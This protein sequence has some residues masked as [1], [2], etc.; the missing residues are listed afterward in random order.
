ML[1]LV[2]LS[3]QESETDDALL[4]FAQKYC[5]CLIFQS[6][7][8][9]N[10]EKH[11]KAFE[12]WRACLGNCSFISA[13]NLA[14][15]NFPLHLYGHSW[16]Q[17]AFVQIASV[18]ILAYLGFS[19]NGFANLYHSALHTL[20]SVI[21]PQIWFLSWFKPQPPPAPGS[22]SLTAPPEE[23]GRELGR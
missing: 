17:N 2:F 20:N 8:A 19:F 3:L 9:L 12:H 13:G 6:E 15:K 5:Y 16:L 4:I 1:L 11:R 21:N 10:N 22:C 7:G 18:F 14:R 23:L